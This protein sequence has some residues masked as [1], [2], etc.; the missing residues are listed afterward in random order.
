[1]KFKNRRY[2]PST[3]NV[4]ERKSRDIINY[5]LRMKFAAL[6]EYIINQF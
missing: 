1:M 6:T 2:L 4:D 3:E 5:Q